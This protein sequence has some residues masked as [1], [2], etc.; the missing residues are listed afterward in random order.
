MKHWKI[1][2]HDQINDRYEFPLELDLDRDNGKYLSPEADRSVRNL[3][4]LHRLIVL[5]HSMLTSLSISAST[6]LC[7]LVFAAGRLRCNLRKKLNH[8]WKLEEKQRDVW[9]ICMIDSLIKVSSSITLY[10]NLYSLLEFFVP[11][12]AQSLAWIG[13]C[14]F[15]VSL[16]F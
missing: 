8:S 4:M 10:R 6:I 13:R 11:C 5:P 9:E 16:F 12:H 1:C 2:F 3:Y 14:E 15:S 7:V